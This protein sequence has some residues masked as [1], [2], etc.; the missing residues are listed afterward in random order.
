MSH[1]SFAVN[2]P[3][4]AK[5]CSKKDGSQPEYKRP[6]QRV[7]IFSRAVCF[8]V[9]RSSFEARREGVADDPATGNGCGFIHNAE[10][11]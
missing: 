9:L 2:L 4:G 8:C 7:S 10:Y 11:Y 6:R 5:P 1:R 3:S